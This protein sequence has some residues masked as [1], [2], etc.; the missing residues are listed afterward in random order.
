MIKPSLAEGFFLSPPLPR[1][2]E[3]WAVTLSVPTLRPP[4]QTGPPADS[5]VLAGRQ[6]LAYFP[7]HSLPAI[8]SNQFRKQL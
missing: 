6:V 1:C 5:L 2:K 4:P 8:V 3:P 7:L